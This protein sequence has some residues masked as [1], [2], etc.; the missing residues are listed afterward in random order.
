MSDLTKKYLP[1][2]FLISFC[3]AAIAQE[4]ETVV[5]NEIMASNS[6]TI[7][8]ED[9]DYEDWVELYNAGPDTVDLG[10]YGLSDDYERPFRWVIP[11]G[12]TIPPGGFLLI[13]ASGKDRSNPE[14]ELH[15]NFSILSGGEEILLTSFNGTRND[16]HEARSIPTDI[17]YGRYPDGADSW[18]YFFDPTPGQPNHE[19]GVPE[20]LNPPSFS[21]P[22]GFYQQPVELEI[23]TGYDDGMILYTLDGSEP[24]ISNVDNDGEA[25]QVEYFFPG[26][27]EERILAER[28]NVTYIYSN[29]LYLSNR[30]SQPNAVADIIT[31]YFGRNGNYRWHHPPEQLFKGNVV[32]A[33]KY[34]SGVQSETV[35]SSFFIT[36]ESSPVL[37]LPVISITA[38]VDDLFGFDNG[39]YIPGRT[40]YEAGGDPHNFVLEANYGNR[41]D[42]WERPVHV[43]F[44]NQNGYSFFSQNAGARIHGGGSRRNQNKSLRIY[45]RSEYDS[46]NRFNYE[47]FPGV[48]KF[49]DGRP[50]TTFNRLLLRADGNLRNYLNDIVSLRLL[51]PSQVNV[52]RSRPFHHFIN[53]EYWGFIYLRDRIDRFHIGYNYDIDPENVIMIESP[54]GEYHP[55]FV[56][57]GTTDDFSY[58]LDMYRYAVENDLSAPRHYEQ[59]TDM[60]DI[61][62]YIDHN[63]AFIY[64]GNVDWYGRRH[65]RLWRVRET[66]D[67][68][69]HDGKWRYM[70]W[71]FDE[72]GRIR[73]LNYDLLY[74]A[75]SPDGGGEPPYHFGNDRG[76]T[77]FLINLLENKE[78]RNLF[79]NRFADHIN[80]TFH[81]E[82]VAR[83]TNEEFGKLEP[84]LD[85]HFFRFG[86]PATREAT[87]DDFITYG[88]KRPAIQFE[89]IVK[90]FDLDG[91]IDI[92]L[93]V[94]DQSEGY[95][96]INTIDIQP[97]TPGVTYMPYPWRG[98][99]FQNIPV[100]LEAKS[101]FGFT[102]SHWEGV[103]DS[104]AQN[105]V[106]TI[107]SDSNVTVKAVYKTDGLSAFPVS[108][109]LEKSDY[110]FTSWDPDT[111]AGSFPGSMAFVYMK[112]D[113][114]D[115][116]SEKDG[117]TYG[118]YNLDSHTRINGLGDDGIALI[119]ATD[120]DGNPGY[121]GRKL[122]GAILALDTRGDGLAT[123][124]WTGGTVSPNSL[125]YRIRMQYRVGNEGPFVDIRDL[126]GNPVEYIRNKHVGHEK[127][128][129]EVVLPPK[130]QNKKYVQVLWR[131]YHTGERFNLENNLGDQLRLD[132]IT[133]TK[134]PHTIQLIK[135]DIFVGDDEVF[136]FEWTPSPVA[137]SYTIEISASPDFEVITYRSEG[138]QSSSHT[139]QSTWLTDSSQKYYWRISAVTN[140]FGTVMSETSDF[141]VATGVDAPELPEV[142]ALMQNYP[143][144]FNP[145]TQIGYTIPATTHVTLEIFDIQGRRVATLVDDMHNSGFYTVTFEASDLASGLY[146]YR[147]R[148][149]DFS[150]TK[151]MIL[152]K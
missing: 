8:D 115:L 47:F 88:K 55:S 29:P 21:H 89:H 43:D 93:E 92:T 77:L 80:S 97:E 48:R 45:A 98:S 139:L 67:D 60:L 134:I 12:V 35:T 86:F 19:E 105:P 26:E 4:Q 130:A 22:S 101:W 144:P 59:I 102:F 131:Y 61:L 49:S 7:S 140:G 121:P 33:A 44:I 73:H 57:E 75:I 81:P 82:R 46:E 2:L 107:A 119:N 116:V 99:Y 23:L 123:V 122:G 9:G 110:G 112:D 20:L 17:S 117:F 138:L 135:P 137:I 149:G 62:S 50:L 104:I 5:I 32:R 151:K 133:A 147:I 106:I 132:N 3:T 76:Q 109:P 54:H 70:V 142:F 100:T 128:F 129:Y 145:S 126:K 18:F 16:Q 71:D 143:N 94:S 34:R 141:K 1:V 69:W 58:Y 11:Q 114:P 124:S 87:R 152:V 51:G 120:Q 10:W 25:F 72:G 15:T 96:R 6:S 28:R 68:P 64:L 39:I 40:Y 24:D 118:A 79:L 74:N 52:Q 103:A 38:Q 83:V 41:G 91:T 14:S 30:T 148:A 42:S 63:I 56:E 111:S 36:D 65:F 27:S 136:H 125:E 31:T 108:H 150:R 66:S 90:N 113:D 127:I 146:L 84:D 78:F 95:I 13:W 53:G 85:D 37:N